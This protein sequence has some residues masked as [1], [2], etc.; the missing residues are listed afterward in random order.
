MTNQLISF[1]ITISFISFSQAAPDNLVGDLY[2]IDT[3]VVSTERGNGVEFRFCSLEEEHINC[4]EKEPIG[5]RAFTFEEL[6]E[7]M[8][9][10][11]N[12][13]KIKLAGAVV[14][15]ILLAGVTYLATAAVITTGVVWAKLGGLSLTTLK[16][17]I[18]SVSLG[19]G[20]V[21]VWFEKVNPLRQ[22]EQAEILEKNFINC[23][24]KASDDEVLKTYDLL[25]DILTYYAKNNPV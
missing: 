8:T 25:E 14:G 1:F 17:I 10:E 22:F 11:R 16:T 4:D 20:S 5:N 12:E 18:V 6:E 13:A 23:D 7:V 9:D 24:D 3:K 19:V 21:P 2:E 15:G